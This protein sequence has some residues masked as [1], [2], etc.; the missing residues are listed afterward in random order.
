MAA[1]RLCAHAILRRA[2]LSNKPANALIWRSH[3]LAGTG[4]PLHGSA[5]HDLTLLDFLALAFFVAAWLGY[6]LVLEKGPLARRSLNTI[7]HG[8]RDQWMQEML[9]REVRIIDTQIMASLQNG[10]A[11]FAS[12]S[13]LAVGGSLALLRVG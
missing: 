4:G 12:T 1:Q 11:F 2:A 10:T 7:M 3:R 6:A 9:N 13:L 8:Y 5:M